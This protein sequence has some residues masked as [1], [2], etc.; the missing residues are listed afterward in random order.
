M[1]LDI[2][3]LEKYQQINIRFYKNY[4]FSIYYMTKWDLFQVEMHDSTYQNYYYNLPH[5]E[6]KDKT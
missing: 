1:S 6:V 2:E 5:Q 4:T 3:D